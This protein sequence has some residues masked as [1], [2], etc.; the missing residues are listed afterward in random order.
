MPC[1]LKT[2]LYGMKRDDG[3]DTRLVAI[4]ERA[5]RHSQRSCCSQCSRSTHY[6]YSE[7]L[8]NCPSAKDGS[9]A[10]VYWD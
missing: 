9:C 3:I 8:P 7:V 5:V 10:K 1:I 6:E 4:A 2:G